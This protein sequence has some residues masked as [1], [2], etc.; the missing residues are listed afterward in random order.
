MANLNLSYKG[1]GKPFQEVFPP[2]LKEDAINNL[3][4][5]VCWTMKTNNIPPERVWNLDETA[6]KMIGSG[7]VPRARSQSRS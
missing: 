3:K 5:K 7:R 1:I 2:D 4:E 6:L